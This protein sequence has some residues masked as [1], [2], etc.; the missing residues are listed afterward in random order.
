MF[1]QQEDSI[2]RSDDKLLLKKLAKIVIIKVILIFLIWWLFMKGYRVA[3]DENK[4]QEQLV[5]A[6]PA[7]MGLT[8][9]YHHNLLLPSFVLV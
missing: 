3:V 7:K 8:I 2:M 6:Y 9:S 5:L 4:M 1:S